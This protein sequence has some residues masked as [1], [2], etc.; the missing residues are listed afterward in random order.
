[1]EVEY[2]V[3]KNVGRLKNSITGG[4]VLMYPVEFSR[5]TGQNTGVMLKYRRKHSATVN[6]TSDYE[7]LE[8]GLGLYLR[9]KIMHIDDVFLN[10]TTRE[11]LLPGFYDYWTSHRNGYLL[12]DASVGYKMGDHYK[13]SLMVKNLTNT[14][15]MGRPGDI[16]P[17]RSF[18]LRLAGSF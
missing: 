12:A 17:Q 5:G 7:N 1:M 18:S 2:A 4:Y 14:E 16:Q 9:S 13:L 10:P 6:F 8:F 11:G 3:T 15:Y